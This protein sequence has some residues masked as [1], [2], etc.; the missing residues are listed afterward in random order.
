MKRDADGTDSSTE[1]LVA[2]A[3]AVVGP[4]VVRLSRRSDAVTLPIAESTRV[5]GKPPM[6]LMLAPSLSVLLLRLLLKGVG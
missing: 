1:V 2:E 3:E 4:V 5:V 6:L